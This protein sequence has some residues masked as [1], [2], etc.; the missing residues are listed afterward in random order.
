MKDSLIKITKNYTWC[1][2]IIQKNIEIR[3]YEF[4]L[5]QPG[6]GARLGDR[7]NLSYFIEP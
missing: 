5:G 2:K 1:S 6:K 3:L 4:Y 7:D